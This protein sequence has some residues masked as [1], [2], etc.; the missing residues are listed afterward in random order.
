MATSAIMIPDFPLPPSQNELYRNVPGV[1][2]VAT[3]ALRDYRNTVSRWA[4]ANAKYR[5]LFEVIR[6]EE[7]GGTSIFKVDTYFIFKHER[8][9][10]KDLKPK[11]LDASN[12]I[13]AC[14]DY[15]CDFLG[16]DDKQIWN[17]SAEK[18]SGEKE[19]VVI[20]ISPIAPM[21]SVEL[22]EQF[23][24]NEEKVQIEQ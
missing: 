21:T 4:F 19:G 16:I 9:W 15:L 22:L 13:K 6:D 17:C 5:E 23:S 8:I 24:D 3:K 1:G 14:H 11:R 2:R 12:R 18:L 20:L 7:W 10:T